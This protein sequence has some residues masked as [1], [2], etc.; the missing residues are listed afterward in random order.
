LDAQNNVEGEITL[1]KEE[2]TT[3][4]KMVEQCGD[5][6]QKLE[7]KSRGQSRLEESCGGSQSPPRAVILLLLMV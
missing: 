5:W 7:R 3:A 2:W 4:Y 1:L 6:G